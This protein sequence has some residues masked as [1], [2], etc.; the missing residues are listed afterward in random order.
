MDVFAAAPFLD[1]EDAVIV[2]HMERHGMRELVSYDTDFDH[3]P[4]I[5]RKEPALPTAS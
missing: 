1:F 3:T 5:N 2:A 4:A